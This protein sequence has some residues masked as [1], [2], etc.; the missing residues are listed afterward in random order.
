MVGI[1]RGERFIRPGA[2]HIAAG[3]LGV[4]GR[5]SELPIGPAPTVHS[6]SSSTPGVVVGRWGSLPDRL[7]LHSSCLRRLLVVNNA[8]CEQDPGFSG[9]VGVTQS[10]AV[11][12]DLVWISARNGVAVNPS[13]LSMLGVSPGVGTSFR[14]FPVLVCD[15]K[16][17]H[18]DT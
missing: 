14:H 11:L 4:G 3:I 16:M 6:L 7:A 12:P 13:A 2:R 18:I 8:Q 10:E 1:T 5:P 15:M 17:K 9:L